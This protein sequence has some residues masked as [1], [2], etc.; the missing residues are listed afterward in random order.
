M[1]R[2]ELLNLLNMVGEMEQIDRDFILGY[3]IAKEPD[4]TIEAIAA[5]QAGGS[6][7]LE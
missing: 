3:L 7:R 2:S 5:M 4:R 1:E 6:F